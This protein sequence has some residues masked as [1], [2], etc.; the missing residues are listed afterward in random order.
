M[1]ADKAAAVPGDG[2]PVGFYERVGF[3]PTGEVVDD[4]F[5]LRLS[6]LSLGR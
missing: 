3:E 4:E 6:A 2:S 1:S 5:V